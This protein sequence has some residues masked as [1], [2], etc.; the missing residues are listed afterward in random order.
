MDGKESGGSDAGDLSCDVDAAC[1]SVGEGV[2]D[3]GAVADDEE[4]GDSGFEVGVYFDFHVIEFD[5]DAV[6]EGIVVSGAGCDLIEG[7]DHFDN[8]VED[9]FGN[10]EGEVAGGSGECR[11]DEVFLDARNGASSAADEVAEALD[12]DAAAEHI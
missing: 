2:G 6:E 9:T 5:F 1:G 7:V 11:G 12:H 4:A 3:A 10:D 8:A